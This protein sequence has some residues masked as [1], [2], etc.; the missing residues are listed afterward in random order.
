MR[1]GVLQQLFGDLPGKAGEPVAVGGAEDHTAL[2]MVE[3]QFLPGTG[4]GHIGQPALFLHFFWIVEHRHPWEHA[5]F[6]AGQEHHR[7]FQTLGRVNGHHHGA[8]RVLVVV[9][10]V[11]E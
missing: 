11:G 6:P 10:Q 2:R 8:V 1:A 3:I 4:D 5:F 7:E 9:V